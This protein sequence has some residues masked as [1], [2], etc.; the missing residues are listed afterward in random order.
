MDDF[1]TR[2]MNMFIGVEQFSQIE[3]ALFPTGSFANEL[4]VDLRQLIS[5][6]ET[7]ASAQETGFGTARQ[8]GQSKDAARAELKES[9]EAIS[10]T[11]RVM[12]VTVPGLEDKFRAPRSVSD[13]ALLAI[14][15]SFA[16]EAA[17]IK[18]EFI[19]RGLPATFIEDLNEDIAAFEE[20][21]NQRVQ[22]TQGHITATAAIDELTERGM[23]IVRELD[24]IMRNTL[25]NNPA[26]LAAWMS[27]SHVERA[28]RRR[29]TQPPPTPPAP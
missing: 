26:K 22:G 15:R 23:Q 18:A 8:G 17:P 19:K 25:A 14:A 21:M 27:A 16:A 10:R 7:Q 1:N 29:T 24:A 12:S 28:P 3:A 2:R 6:L 20:A 9:L 13:Q 4:V 5:E 11:A